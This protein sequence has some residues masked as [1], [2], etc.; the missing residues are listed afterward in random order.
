MSEL[1]PYDS[2]KAAALA[3]RPLT[4]NPHQGNMR[5]IKLAIEWAKGWH[6]GDAS[7]AV[8][9]PLQLNLES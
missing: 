7:A 2:G 1:S 5:F 3:G 4:D 6:A 8:S 9:H